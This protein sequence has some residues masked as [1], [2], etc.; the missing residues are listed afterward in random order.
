MVAKI[1]MS[2]AKEVKS[3]TGAVRMVCAVETVGLKMDVMVR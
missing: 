1:A 2:N 3:A